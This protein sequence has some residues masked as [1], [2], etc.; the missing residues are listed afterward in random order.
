MLS[1]IATVVELTVVVVPDTVKLPLT[2]TSA[3]LKLNALLNEFVNEFKLLV[4]VSINP[5]LVFALELNV[6]KLLVAV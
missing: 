1:P 2:V 4:A 6:F 5:N 3:P